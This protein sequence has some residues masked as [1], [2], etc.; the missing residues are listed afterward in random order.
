MLTSRFDE[1]TKVRTTLETTKLGVT[2]TD[3]YSA[4][5]ARSEK[6]VRAS[7]ALRF[8]V[9]NLE[10]GEG[11]K[12]SYATGL[13]EDPF[14]AMCDHLIVEHL[15]TG[16]IIGVYRLQTGLNA[17]ANRGYYCAQEFEFDVFEPYRTELIELGRAC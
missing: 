7:Q 15:P 11:L 13:D 10:L 17:S 2:A 16:K 5:L 6:E 4:R 8:E 9:F 1:I 3:L 12:E 14:D